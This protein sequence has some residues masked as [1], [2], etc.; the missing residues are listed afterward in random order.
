MFNCIAEINTLYPAFNFE[1]Y[2]SPDHFN[3]DILN[4]QANEPLIKQ[5][6]LNLLLN[7]VHY[8]DNQEAN[9]TSD[10][11]SDLLTLIVSNSGKARKD[12]QHQLIFTHSFRVDTA[13]P[14][15]R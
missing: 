8:S 11:S 2:F 5:A 10:R 1:V 4:R 3:E 6:L 14:S 7:A 13:Q 15:Q 12:H 9:V